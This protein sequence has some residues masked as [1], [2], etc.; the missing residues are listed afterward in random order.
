MEERPAD[1]LMGDSAW[2]ADKAREG[3]GVG[4]QGLDDAAAYIARSFKSFGLS[5]LEGD[6]YR[7]EFDATTKVVTQATFSVGGGQFD[8]A[9]LRAFGFSSSI[10]VDGPLAYVATNEDFAH[11]DVKGKIVVVRQQGRSNLAHTAWVAHDR[12]AVGLLVVADGP[13]S[14][15]KPDTGSTSVARVVVPGATTTLSKA[16]SCSGGSPSPDG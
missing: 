10:A 15:A 1:H 11:V 5:P 9:K 14:E 13:L 12:G 4:S 2:L 3:R 7:Q 16:R 8:G 6:D